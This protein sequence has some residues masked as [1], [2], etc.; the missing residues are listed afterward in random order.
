MTD[1]NRRIKEFDEEIKHLVNISPKQFDIARVAHMIAETPPRK[2]KA[3]QARVDATIYRKNAQQNL[4]ALKASLMLQARRDASL[5]AAPDRTAW[6]DSQLEVH[7]AELDLIN[8]DAEET[9]AELAYE[10]LDDLFTAGKKIMQYLT[11]QE[12]ATKDYNKYVDEGRRQ[13]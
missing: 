5:K 3:A 6:V 9:A 12:K 10:A 13:S 4:K 8:A 1:L 7:Q 2:W 11:D